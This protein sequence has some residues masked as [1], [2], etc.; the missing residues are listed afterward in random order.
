MYMDSSN[1]ESL[2]YNIDLQKNK[3]GFL[4][5]IMNMVSAVFK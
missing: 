5:V 1:V 2:K 4:T 3:N